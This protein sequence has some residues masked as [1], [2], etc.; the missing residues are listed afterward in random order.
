MRYLPPTK[1]SPRDIVGSSQI[2]LGYVLPSPL[3]PTVKARFKSSLGLR[4]EF[5]LSFKFR[6]RSK[7][8]YESKVNLLSE[9]DEVFV[10]GVHVRELAVDKH[11]DLV[12]ASLLKNIRIMITTLLTYFVS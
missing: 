2:V 6:T 12:F 8:K 11:E 4:K 1:I 5:D 9:S 7:D 10:V 3:L